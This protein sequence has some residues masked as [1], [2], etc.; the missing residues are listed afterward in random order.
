MQHEHEQADHTPRFSR[1]LHE[2]CNEADGAPRFSG[3]LHQEREQAD[4]APRFS[5]GFHWEGERTETDN[6]LHL[7]NGPAQPSNAGN[8]SYGFH[9]FSLESYQPSQGKKRRIETAYVRPLNFAY[10][11]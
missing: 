8:S 2:D 1:G 6:T 3:G 10:M 7:S 4:D 11:F 9:V 5:R